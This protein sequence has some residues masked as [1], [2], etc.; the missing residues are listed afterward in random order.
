MYVCVHLCM[1][2]TRFLLKKKN[3]FENTVVVYLNWIVI[4]FDH[5]V[6]GT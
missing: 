2:Q 4:A 5:S 1:C 3:K 6:D